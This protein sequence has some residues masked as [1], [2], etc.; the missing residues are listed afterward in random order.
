MTDSMTSN[1]NENSLYRQLAEECMAMAKHAYSSGLKVPGEI[2]DT[3]EAL[4]KTD[5]TPSMRDLNFAHGKLSRMVTPAKPR[6]I[7]LLAKEK[8][9]KHWFSFLGALPLTRQLMLAALIC[10]VCFILLSLSPEIDNKPETWNLFSSQGIPLLFRLLFLIFASGLGA[11]FA[12]LFRVNTYIVNGTYDPKYESSYWIRFSL[13]IIAGMIL[14]TLIP[15][16]QSVEADFGKPLLAMLGGFSAEA[17]YRILARLVETLNSLIAG[18][19]KDQLAAT[20]REMAARGAEEESKTKF[21]LASDLMKIHGD[22]N[23]DTNTDD[24]KKKISGLVDNLTE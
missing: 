8:D 22:I 18:D 11:S 12:A 20:Q 6:S 4:D 24:L 17:V 15:I 23:T 16:E 21:K 2:A 3:L 9:K 7:L 14:A 19:R 10:L 1:T 5:K 13:G